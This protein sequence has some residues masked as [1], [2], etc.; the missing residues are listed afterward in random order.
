MQQTDGTALPINEINRAAISHIDSKTNSA[1]ICNQ[2]VAIVEAVVVLQRSID[3]CNFTS[4]HLP[5]GRQRPLRQCESVS[6]LPVRFVETGED[7]SFVVREGDALYASHKSMQDIELFQRTK[8][9][10]G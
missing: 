9:L 5:Y 7:G 3:Y 2:S 8:S 4:V 6:Y 10:D 1:L